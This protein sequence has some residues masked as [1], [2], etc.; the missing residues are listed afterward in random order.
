MKKLSERIILKNL[1]LQQF[2]FVMRKVIFTIF[3]GL[4]SF[5]AFGQFYKLKTY[6]S[7]M[8]TLNIHGIAQDSIT[9]EKINV[10]IVVTELNSLYTTLFS[11][12]SLMAGMFGVILYPEGV[13]LVS[14]FP[15]PPHNLSYYNKSIVID[16]RCSGNHKA[17]YSLEMEVNFSSTHYLTIPLKIAYYDKKKD[18]YEYKDFVSYKQLEKECPCCEENGKEEK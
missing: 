15:S 6:N 16:T 2:S 17:G 10:N 5:G 8:T 12:S 1:K 11:Y 7:N 14:F 3:L 4:M 18:V 13:Y 9:K